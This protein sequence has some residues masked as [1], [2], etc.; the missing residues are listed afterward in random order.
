MS[1]LTPPLY[2]PLCR[3]LGSIVILGKACDL[4]DQHQQSMSASSPPAKQRTQ[5]KEAAGE[6]AEAEDEAF[7]EE[8]EEEEESGIEEAKFPVGSKVEEI[9]PAVATAPSDLSREV[10]ELCQEMVLRIRKLKLFKLLDLIG[11]PEFKLG[12]VHTI[13]NPAFLAGHLSVPA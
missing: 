4:I 1:C 9:V 11:R 3:I 7:S 13:G 2:S 8:E 6:A 12:T 5:E 10:V